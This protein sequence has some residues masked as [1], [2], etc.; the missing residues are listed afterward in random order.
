MCTFNVRK[1]ADA[2]ISTF[3]IEKRFLEYME[4][5]MNL[6]FSEASGLDLILF[7]P[8]ERVSIKYTN[9]MAPKAELLSSNV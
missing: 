4:H 5:G 7:N 2:L 1:N 8:L 6:Q 3:D 9:G